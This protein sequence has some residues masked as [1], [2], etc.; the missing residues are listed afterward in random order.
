MKKDSFRKGI[1]IAGGLG[2]RL[3]PL[4]S[5]ISKQLLP[6]YD[7]P[8]I[9]YPL[10][11]LMLSGV[12]DIL[13]ITTKFSQSLFE[14]LLGDGSEWGMN[15]SYKV[16]EKCYG[17][18]HAISLGEGFTCDKN[19]V[20]A[21]GDN[22]FHGTNF[23]SFLQ[24]ADI[25]KEGAT[26]FTYPVKDPQR[27]GVISYDK[28]GSILSLQEKPTNPNSNNAIT[29]L[30]FFDKSVYER[31]RKLE[32]STRNELEITGLISS[33]LKDNLLNVESFGRGMAWFDTGTF[34]SLQ[35]GSEYIRSIQNRQG[36]K[37]GCPE[38]ISWRQGWINDNQLTNLADKLMSGGYGEYLLKLIDINK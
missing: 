18:S 3:Y 19:I 30:Y 2:S 20:I 6:V 8:M 13:I 34:D 23:V 26:I 25:R 9:Y 15:F 27:Y 32:Y 28:K 7:K 16:Q 33:Y 35:E 4:T 38:E 22:I 12:K 21:L 11:T 17:V 10:T 37:V 24:S 31:I 36:L 14:K 5:V 1:L 29:G